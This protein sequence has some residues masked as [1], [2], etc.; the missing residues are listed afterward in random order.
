MALEGIFDFFFFFTERVIYT[1]SF[2]FSLCS[3]NPT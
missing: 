2:K 1:D 3:V